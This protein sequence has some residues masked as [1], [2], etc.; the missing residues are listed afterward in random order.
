MAQ[1]IA[2]VEPPVVE[3]PA[4]PLDERVTA[5]GAPYFAPVAVVGQEE[6]VYRR[7]CEQRVGEARSIAGTK[8]R[9]TRPLPLAQLHVPCAIALPLT[10]TAASAASARTTDAPRCA[11]PAPRR[12]PARSSWVCTPSVPWSLVIHRWVSLHHHRTPLGSS[13]SRATLSSTMRSAACTERVP[14]PRGRCLVHA[15][16]GSEQ[17]VG[18]AAPRTRRSSS[19]RDVAVDVEPSLG[20]SAEVRRRGAQ[21]RAGVMPPTRPARDNPR[22]TRSW[23]RRSWVQLEDR[24]CRMGSGS[25]SMRPIS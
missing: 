3:S 25:R 12:T 9:P 17:I 13:L 1:R 11:A 6:Q 21:R 7:P 16:E 4:V 20:L 19:I 22:A 8:P 2:A 24:R 5:N 18:T 14:C 10:I 15:L 23:Q